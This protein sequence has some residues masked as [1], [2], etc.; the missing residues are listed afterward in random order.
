LALLKLGRFEEALNACRMALHLKPELPNAHANIGEIRAAQGDLD[1]AV[2][3]YEQ[4]IR[5]GPEDVGAYV[6]FGVLLTR[7]GRFDRAIEVLEKAVRLDKRSFEASQNLAFTY[8][9]SGRPEKAI[10]IYERVAHMHPNRV[11]PLV[12]LAAS[13]IDVGDLDGAIRAYRQ[14]LRVKDDPDVWGYIA[15]LHLQRGVLDEAIRAFGEQ[16]KRRATPSAVVCLGVCHIHKGENERAAKILAEATTRWPKYALAHAN[17]GSALANLQRTGAAISAFKK[18]ISLDAG[19][20]EAHLGLGNALFAKSDFAGA[21][22]SYRD[23]IDQRPMWQ[24]WNGL[25][26]SL[27]KLD[28]VDDALLAYRETVRLNPRWTG[29]RLLIAYHL[30]ARGQFDEALGEYEKALQ[31][32]PNNPQ[33]YFGMGWAQFETGGLAKARGSWRHALQLAPQNALLRDQM[34]W[35]LA[36]HENSELRDPKRAVEL[37]RKAVGL[38]K[39]LAQVWTTLGAALYRNREFKESIGVLNQASELRSGETAWEGFFLAMAHAE[40]DRTERA[41]RHHERAVAWMAKNAPEDP[42]L[43]RFRAES[44]SLLDTR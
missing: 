22:R 24:A 6:N 1:G 40:L 44:E 33:V 37:A 38:Q 32:D 39:Q 20:A 3:A 36:N 30:R 10:P 27:M 28:R 31:V 13:R 26:N 25:G 34:A 35:L 18:A 15:Q 2:E 16:I 9:E 29:A 4:A 19:L 42:Q 43:A 8:K 12:W 17:L 11:E 41:R 14:S 21:E 7:N 5:F 23:C